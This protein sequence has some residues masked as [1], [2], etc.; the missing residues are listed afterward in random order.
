MI[1]IV[2]NPGIVSVIVGLVDAVLNQRTDLEFF[3]EV[4]TEPCT[5]KASIGSKDLQLA[6]V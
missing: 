5:V 4:L 6:R 2:I 3:S 1:E